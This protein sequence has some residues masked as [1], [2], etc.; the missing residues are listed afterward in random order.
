MQRISFAKEKS[1]VIA[2]VEGTFNLRERPKV[3]VENRGKEYLFS[4]GDESTSL[5]L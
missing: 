2:K 1:D 3:R 4:F 5:P